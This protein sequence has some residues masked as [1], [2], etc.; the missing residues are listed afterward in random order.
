MEGTTSLLSLP[1]GM[2][3]EHIQATSTC[4]SVSVIATHPSSCCPLCS[5][6]SSSIH[7]H[8]SRMLRDV[9]CGGRSVQLF[10][11]EKGGG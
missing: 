7:S 11:S 9:P 1:E 10:L 3:I 8:Y 2:Q 4:I 5:Q 6:P